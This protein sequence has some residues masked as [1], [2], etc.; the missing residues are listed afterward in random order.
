MPYSCYGADMSRLLPAR[1][2][3][4]GA[5]WD[6]L[7]WFTYYSWLHGS[8]AAPRRAPHGTVAVFGKR[9]KGRF[10]GPNLN[11]SAI[12][13]LPATLDWYASEILDIQSF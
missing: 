13:T 1:T 6:T 8:P 7:R 11:F 3:T 2:A 5:C 9:R 4:G 10:Q 12:Y